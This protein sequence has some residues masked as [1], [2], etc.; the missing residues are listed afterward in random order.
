ME[1]ALLFDIGSTFTK[2]RLVDL[3]QGILLASSEAET[4]VQEDVSLGV[5]R[6][7]EE[8]GDW[9]QAGIRLGCSSAAGGLRLIAIGLV[10]SLTAEAARRAALGAGARVLTTFSY[11]LSP[12]EVQEIEALAP[13][14]I[15]LAGG[16]DGGNREHLLANSRLLAQS[17]W[18]CPLVLAGNIKARGQ[19]QALLEEGEFQVFPTENVM[20]ELE[21]LNIEPCR[22]L[23]RQVFLERITRARG[24]ENLPAIDNVLMPTPAAVME[25][26]DLLQ[27]GPGGADQGWGDIMVADIGGATTD[28]HSLAEGTPRQNGVTPRGLPE[29]RAKRTVEGDLGLRYNARNIVETW[30][31]DCFLELLEKIFP[32]GDWEQELENYLSRLEKNPGSVPLTGSEQKIDAALGRAAMALSGD[33]HCGKMERV[34]TPQGP[35]L[36]QYGKDLTGVPCIIGCG[37]VLARGPTPEV[38]IDGI[39]AGTGD[40]GVL[41]P[42][43]PA[44]YLDRDYIMFAAGLLAQRYPE[45]AFRLMENSLIKLERGTD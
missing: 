44:Y 12:E 5:Q 37:G 33:R 19:A 7:L 29:P 8:L 25:A 21:V 34:F 17:D 35:V 18:S 30:S 9:E 27:R 32:A 1:Q 42:E 28:I 24:L 36:F 41:R 20:P 43:N 3:E 15:L 14:I 39:A 40:E 23:I 45:A 16:T 11:R 22:K 38:V 10:P 31:K 13:D 6:T 2:A 4:T 26:A